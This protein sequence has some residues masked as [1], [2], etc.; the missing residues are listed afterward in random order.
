MPSTD[1]SNESTRPSS[2]QSQPG[3]GE[4][5]IVRD[6][7]RRRARHA[8]DRIAAS[9]SVETLA[10]ALTA[11]TDFGAIARAL[12]DAL[13]LGPASDLDPLADALARG[14]TERERLIVAAGGLLSA[15]EVGRNLGG[16]T[17]QA[18]DKRRRANQLLGVRIGGDWRYPA[19][20]FEADG[21]VPPG[22]PTLLAAM[23]KAGPWATLDF[24]LAEDDALGGLSPMAALHLGGTLADGVRRLILASEV[25]AFG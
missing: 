14:A 3:R 20:Q 13:T 12:G 7:F 24:L 18:V 6:A 5:E 2:A 8:I 11:P 22:L 9:A 16:I 1:L 10:D 23:A 19:V 17:R 15:G 21:G 25:D 4:S